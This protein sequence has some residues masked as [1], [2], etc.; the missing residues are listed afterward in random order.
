MRRRLQ[1]IEDIVSSYGL[2]V[3]VEWVPTSTNVADALT[4][5]PQSWLKNSK[6]E[7]SAVSTVVPGPLKLSEIQTGQSTDPVLAQALKQLQDGQEVIAKSLQTWS[8]TLPAS[9]TSSKKSCRR[10]ISWRVRRKQSRHLLLVTP[11]SFVALTE[12]RSCFLLSNVGGTS[13]K[14]SRPRLLSSLRANRRS[15]SML[16]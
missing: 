7:V 10:K 8:V 1:L 6:I 5:V 3:T 9:E 11:S 12:A 16:T 13:K 14:F 2:G 4:W 15:W